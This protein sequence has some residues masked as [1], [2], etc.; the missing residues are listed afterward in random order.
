[1][2][3]KELITKT[4]QVEEYDMTIELEPKKKTKFDKAVEFIKVALSLIVSSMVVHVLST[5][6]TSS[7]VLEFI[8][9]LGI[10]HYIVK[11]FK[12]SFRLI[13]EVIREV[14]L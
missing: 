12:I 9:A 5:H 4:V 1:M 7:E 3:K 14:F 11:A 8:L 6:A 13:G 2:F 10:S